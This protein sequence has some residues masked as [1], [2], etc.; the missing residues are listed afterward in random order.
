MRWPTRVK[1]RNRDP[2]GP[3]IISVM[4]K[5]LEGERKPEKDRDGRVPEALRAVRGKPYSAIGEREK[6][7]IYEDVILPALEE[8]ETMLV[9]QAKPLW[10]VAEAL[11]VKYRILYEFATSESHK[12]LHAIWMREE[13][14]IQNVEDALYRSS[15]GFY[16]TEE[17]PMKKR[18]V[19]DYVNKRG[20]ECKKT[21]EVIEIVQVR[22]YVSPDVNAIRFL[23][24]NRSPSKWMTDARLADGQAQDQLVAAAKD[25]VS[26]VRKAAVD[27][28]NGSEGGE[29]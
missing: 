8:I 4:E 29:K 9:Y 26:K 24:I 13:A 1:R 19:T 20:K 16:M 28:S 18:V 3:A 15:C 22:K 25:I 14:K 10:E 17:V 23:L 5:A 12:E 11:G 2:F 21:E 27:Y 6:E 7:R